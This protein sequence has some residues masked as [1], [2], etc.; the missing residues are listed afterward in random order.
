MFRVGR[1]WPSHDFFVRV[2]ICP[3][4][5]FFQGLTCP[6]H[7]SDLG[8]LV[9]SS[10]EFAIGVLARSSHEFAPGVDLAQS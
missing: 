3:V 2:G 6:C 7:E 4:M 1:T 5:S 9:S 10:H 8:V